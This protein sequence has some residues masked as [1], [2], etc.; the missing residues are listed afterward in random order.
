M[1]IHCPYLLLM[2]IPDPELHPISGEYSEKY[3]GKL[4][5]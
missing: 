2:V 1:D 4:L 5:F 3:L